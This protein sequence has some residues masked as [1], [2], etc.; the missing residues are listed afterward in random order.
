M[1]SLEDTRG[2]LLTPKGATLMLFAE[3]LVATPRSLL[4]HKMGEG[5]HLSSLGV[6]HPGIWSLGSRGKP[7]V[8]PQLEKTPT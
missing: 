4:K 6:G 3:H 7:T 8:T 1:P 5:S 2:L